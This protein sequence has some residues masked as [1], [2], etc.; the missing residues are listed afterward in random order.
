MAQPNMENL[1]D[2]LQAATQE[3][4][5]LPNIPALADTTVLQHQL[6]QIMTR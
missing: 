2:A 6:G 1:S 3:P 4:L 5:L